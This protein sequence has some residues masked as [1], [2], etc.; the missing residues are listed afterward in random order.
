MGI[1]RRGRNHHVFFASGPQDCGR[2][3]HQNAGNTECNRWTKMTQ[4]DRHQKRRE[5]RAEVNDPIKRLEHHFGAVLVSL[6]ELI[7]D[8]CGD[9]RFDPARAKRNQPETDIKTGAVRDKHRQARLACAVN[10]T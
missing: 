7:A 9:T 2:N 8:K 1:R 6:V 10:Q 4:K 5:E 3:K